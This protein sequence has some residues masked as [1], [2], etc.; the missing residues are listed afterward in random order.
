M[1]I[2]YSF[3]YDNSCD[4]FRMGQISYVFKNSS[5]S[6]FRPFCR[7][8]ISHQK[9]SK[10]I[11]VLFG[12]LIS[13]MFKLNF[14]FMLP[15]FQCVSAV[16]YCLFFQCCCGCFCHK[17][18]WV[19]KVLSV[20]VERPLKCRSFSNCFSNEYQ[21]QTYRLVV[22]QEYNNVFLACNLF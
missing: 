22:L 16:S 5:K 15:V 1:S 9:N 2:A 12:Y 18:R 14:I 20:S 10:K 17:N 21:L 19:S 11:N 6:Y 3:I 4:I 8:K 13:L 7:C